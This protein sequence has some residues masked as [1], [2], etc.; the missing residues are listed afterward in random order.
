MQQPVKVGIREFR[1][2]LAAYL[3]SDRPVAVTRHGDTIGL[4]IP[5][6][7]KRP[8]HEDVE[9][10]SAAA[11]K[12]HAMMEAAGVTEDELLEEIEQKKKRKARIP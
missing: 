4:Y 6:P 8:T 5:T 9:A 7:R 11:D 10:F 12:L 3:I 1:E 2:K